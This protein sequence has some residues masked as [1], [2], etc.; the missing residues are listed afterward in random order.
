MFK[1]TK[2]TLAACTVALC[3]SFG[4]A[5]GAAAEDKVSRALEKPLKA[6]NDAFQA[7]KFDEAIAACKQGE[8][9][10]NRSDYDNFVIN[11]LMGSSYV[12]TKRYPEAYPRL[13]AVVESPRVAAANKPGLLGALASIAFAQK[14]Y[15]AAVDWADKAIAAGYDTPEERFLIASGYYL[16][17]KFKDCDSAATDL[18]SREEK[19]GRHPTENSL[20]LLLQCQIQAN[21]AAGQSRTF[22]KLVQYYPKPEYWQN[23]MLTLVNNAKSDERLK[24]QVYR[25]QEEV[26]TLKRAD[27]YSEMVQL[28]MDQGLPAEALRIIDQGMQKNIFTDERVKAQFSRYQQSGQ[29]ALQN[30]KEDLPKAEHEADRTG[31]GDLLVGVGTSYLFNANEA[32]KAIQLI[33]TGISK[34]LQKVPLND[35]YITLGLAY[36]KVKNNSEAL[37][38]FDKVDKNENYER[39]AKLWTLRAH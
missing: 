6:C 29:K 39:L 24:L 9:L 10:P 14:D 8:E 16:Q 35:A 32:N 11:Q 38:A 12:Q 2:P 20:K 13:K 15:A 5:Q 25:L 31:N 17:N 28:S 18:V 4:L 7:K 3:L 34:G 36:L 1:M 19:A 37:K 27:Q 21:N 33:Q 22:E 23:A 26:G 30:E